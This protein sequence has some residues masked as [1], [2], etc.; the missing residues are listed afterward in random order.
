MDAQETYVGMRGRS[1]E[2]EKKICGVMK[3]MNDEQLEL[4]KL[5]QATTD[6]MVLRCKTRLLA[7]L[8]DDI[9]RRVFRLGAMNGDK[10]SGTGIAPFEITIAQVC[11]RWRHLALSSPT[12]WTN[13]Y[14]GRPSK[15]TRSRI[16]AYIERSGTEKLNITIMPGGSKRLPTREFQ[17]LC[18]HVDRWQSF[19]LTLITRPSS[20]VQRFFEPLANVSARELQHF[21][22]RV[23]PELCTQSCAPLFLKAQLFGAGAPQLH[24]MLLGGA[25]CILPEPHMFMR[26]TTLMLAPPHH[27]MWLTYKDLRAVLNA[28]VS[29]RRLI[30][31]GSVVVPVATRRRVLLNRLETLELS[32]DHSDLLF[33]LLEMPVLKALDLD[34]RSLTQSRME[35]VMDAFW[36]PHGAL[37]FPS[38]TSLTLR[39]FEC[40]L[41]LG[42]P[43]AMPA[44]EE[45]AIIA[46]AR[47]GIRDDILL[48]LTEK[49]RN[50]DQV[51]WP[52]LQ[53]LKLG[54]RFKLS[55]LWDV[56]QERAGLGHRLTELSIPRSCIEEELCE[57]FERY[58]VLQYHEDT[59]WSIAPDL[60]EIA[61]EEDD[62]SSIEPTVEDNRN[63]YS[64]DSDSPISSD[65]SEE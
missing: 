53:K 48:T 49:N 59:C 43:D 61:I 42:R 28:T 11:R 13:I 10:R 7:F 6:E 65:S 14:V 47:T 58:F 3:F 46:D 45:L 54:G 64:S 41:V 22:I 51:L 60:P 44:L 1:L 55:L 31:N 62:P 15:G 12:L 57:W 2:N 25:G 21:E 56:C 24:T 34:G 37:R 30:I 33:S 20:D 8:D 4:S 19:K 63:Y 5:L 38:L 29:L 16:Q 17:L 23:S 35:R 39:S 18:G 9:L 40:M 27:V 50:D 32:S 36:K 52:R 26:L